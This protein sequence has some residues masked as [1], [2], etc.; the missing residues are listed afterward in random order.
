MTAAWSPAELQKIDAA[1]E[2]EIAGRRADGT[3]RQWVPIWV[4][5][6]GGLVFVRTWYRRD[7]G[8]FGHVLASRQARIRVPGLEA[9]VAVEDV[10][11]GTHGL[12]A[13]V[14]AAYQTKYGRGGGT[15]RMVSA[16][17]AAATLRLSPAVRL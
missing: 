4:V 11:E 12:R 3:L 13:A 6:T 5:S 8:W 2:L 9:D 1:R 14:D 16:E 17:A 7:T 10:G 15:E